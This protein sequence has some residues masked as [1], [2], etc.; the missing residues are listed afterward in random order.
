[1]SYT[2]YKAALKYFCLDTLE[3][4]RIVLCKKF[5]T[6]ALKHPKH[7]NWFQP[8]SKQT[9]TRQEQPKFCSVYCKTRRFEKSPLNYLTSLLKKYSKNNWTMYILFK[10]II[11]A[12]WK[13]LVLCTHALF[14]L[15]IS[16]HSSLR[17]IK[18]L[19]LSL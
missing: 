9:I 18:R 6:K 4:R 5:S 2:T 7:T 3:N 12:R 19:L 17:K 8:N 15:Y 11:D 10:W 16:C 14:Y 13:E 1:M